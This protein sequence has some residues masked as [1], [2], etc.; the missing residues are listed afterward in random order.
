MCAADSERPQ[1][2]EEELVVLHLP[3]K[4]DAIVRAICGPGTQSA[5]LGHLA[6]SLGTEWSDLC[7]SDPSATA[8]RL[9]ALWCDEENWRE[10][11][12]FTETLVQSGQPWAWQLAGLVRL[13]HILSQAQ[14]GMLD[15]AESE[16]DEL[17]ASLQDHRSSR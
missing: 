3:P 11:F 14:A 13:R 15:T 17:K 10:A 6:R 16:L 2:T 8:R 9:L 5:R 12:P 4:V 1:L 7:P